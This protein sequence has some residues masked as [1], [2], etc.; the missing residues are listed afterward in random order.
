LWRSSGGDETATPYEQELRGSADPES[1]TFV[2]VLPQ[3]EMPATYAAAD[4]IACPSVWP[5]PFPGVVVEAM[6]ARRPV[7]GSRVGGIPEQ[8]RDG[9]TGLLVPPGDPAALAAAIV[10]CAENDERRRA[11]GR[12][13]RAQVE[14]LTWDKTAATIHRLYEQLGAETRLVGSATR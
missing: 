6:A 4:L 9:E 3:S 12:H 8:V 2:G 1:V 5:E 11:Y 14:A 13:G 10:A 7:V